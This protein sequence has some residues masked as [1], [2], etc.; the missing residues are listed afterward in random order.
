MRLRWLRL[1]GLG[2][3]AMVGSGCVVAKEGAWTWDSGVERVVL[4]LGNGDA[5]LVASGSEQTHLDLDFG[6]LSVTPIEPERVGNTVRIDLLCDG[7]CCGDALLEVP[8]HIEVEAIVHRGD[9]HIEGLVGGS[10]DA[11]VAAGDLTVTD[12][13]VPRVGVTVGAGDGSV[14]LDDVRCVSVQVGAGT[15]TIDIP[16]GTY[17]VDVAVDAGHLELDDRIIRS[18]DAEACVH[19]RVQA[20]HLELTGH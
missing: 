17:D 2:L 6:G 5:E 12:V 14:E 4:E 8:D 7:V 13:A 1:D 11:I 18:S 20:G 10:L 3:V 9:L 16:A 15:A 19:G